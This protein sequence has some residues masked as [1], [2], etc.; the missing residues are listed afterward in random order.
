MSQSGPQAPARVSRSLD[1]VEPRRL[2]RRALLICVGLGIAAIV[3]ALP[4]GR[5]ELGT[6]AAAGLVAGALNAPAAGVALGLGAFRLTSL[7]RLGLL[8]LVA[9]ALAFWVS[10]TAGIAF[11]GG[12]AVAQLVVAASS[13]YEGVR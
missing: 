12:L 4:A 3:L 2:L 7:G 5:G 8:T 11:A 6:A 10:P 13:I 1:L 9:T